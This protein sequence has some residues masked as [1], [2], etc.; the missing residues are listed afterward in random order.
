ML[1]L[2]IAAANAV[3]RA[4]AQP[5]PAAPAPSAPVATVH[6]PPLPAQIERRYQGSYSEPVSRELFAACDLDGDDHLDVLEATDSFD[7]L[8]SPRDVDGYA[9]FDVDRDGFIDWPEFDARFRRGIENGG[10]FRVR[11]RRMLSPST[12]PAPPLPPTPLRRFLQLHDTDR[13][14]GLSGAEIDK[15]L[16]VSGLPPTLA[17]QLRLLDLN[18][19]GS[20]DETELAPWF[21][22]LP[23]A[24]RAG[25]NLADP[26]ATPATPLPPPWFAADKDGDGKIDGVELRSV[27]LRMDPLLAR[28][29]MA[30]FGKLDRDRDNALPAADLPLPAP[31]PRD[32]RPAGGPPLARRAAETPQR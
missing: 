11:T 4:Q 31:P 18:G 10:T 2:S 19:S 22:L 5:A 21:E 17:V 6:V 30:L 3:A 12:I 23:P 16:E 28:W 14:G 9:R 27:L 24:V 13:D 32:G 7:S 8:R 15:L 1:C 29:D 25:G 26:T 20:I